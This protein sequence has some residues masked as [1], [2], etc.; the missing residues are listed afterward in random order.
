LGFHSK[1]GGKRDVGSQAETIVVSLRTNICQGR[2]L[3][4]HHHLGC[5]PLHALA[6]ADE[7][8]H[9]GS[10]P[11]IHFKANSRVRLVA[12][13]AGL[14]LLLL[15][16]EMGAKPLVT[17]G[18][19][20]LL[21]VL[22]FVALAILVGHLLGAPPSNFRPTLAAALAMRFPAPAF[23]LAKLYGIL[24][25]IV[26]VIPA[27]L[28]F[29]SVLLALY[30]KLLEKPGVAFQKNAIGLAPGAPKN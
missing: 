7:E 25:P 6:C 10:S 16:L 8:R 17:L 11:G 12:K 29:G 19:R 1:T 18:I 23:V 13:V 14:L 30:H 22:I 3:E 15:I 2:T 28:I 20:S 9:A 26:P 5:G 21:S 4:F 27:Y 24:D